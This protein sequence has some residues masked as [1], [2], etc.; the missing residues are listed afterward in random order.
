MTL[1]QYVNNA[2]VFGVIV[3]TGLFA[4]TKVSAGGDSCCGVDSGDSCVVDTGDGCSD[5]CDNP[6]FPDC[7]PGT[8]NLCT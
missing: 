4:G 5:G 6:N 7:C 3:G 1:R 8:E 2:A